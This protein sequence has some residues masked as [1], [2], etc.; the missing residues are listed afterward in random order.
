[1]AL[2]LYT[3]IKCPLS[4]SR[5]G[6]LT[7]AKFLILS[8]LGLQNIHRDQISAI[9][10]FDLSSDYSLVIIT[11]TSQAIDLNRPYE[12]TN[13]RT[14][15]LKYKK[16]VSAQLHIRVLL[17][18]CHDIDNA[19]EQFNLCTFAV[20]GHSFPLLNGTGGFRKTAS[21]EVQ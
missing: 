15:W 11:I 3:I 20:A 6:P 2:S 8:I 10:N 13:K 16:Y 4:S 1:M 14:N 21:T 19:I 5:I 18:T 12:L 7:C 17:K 9:A